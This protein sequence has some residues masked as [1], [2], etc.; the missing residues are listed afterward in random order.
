MRKAQMWFSSVGGPQRS[1]REGLQ[2][3]TIC[4]MILRH[5]LPFPLSF[6]LECAV[7]FSRTYVNWDGVICVG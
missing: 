7:E 1:F 5:Y 6:F 2:D 3:P 4:I